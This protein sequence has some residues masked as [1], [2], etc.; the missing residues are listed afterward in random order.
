[1]DTIRGEVTG[2][3]PLAFSITEFC[4]LHRISRAHFYNLVKAGLGPRVMDVGGR[5]LIS[6]EAAADW[7]HEREKVA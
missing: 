7:R 3:A 2:R 5:K 1:M 4:A 6:Q